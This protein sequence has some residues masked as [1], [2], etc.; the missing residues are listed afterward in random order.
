M[1]TDDEDIFNGYG[2]RI[3]LK[4]DFVKIREV[5]TRIGI[6]NNKTKTLTQSC[7]IFHKRGQYALMHFKEMFLFDNKTADFTE[8]DEARRN[9]IVK[10]LEQWGMIEILD[11]T[12]ENFEVGPIDS[13]N[14][15]SR[16]M[17]NKENWALVK[18]YTLGKKSVA[19]S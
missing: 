4:T 18:K 3:N 12:S 9:R 15:I 19:T 14:I 6:A 7:H 10:I 1:S 11:D 16:D 17:K 8:Y 5:L 13:V 2:I